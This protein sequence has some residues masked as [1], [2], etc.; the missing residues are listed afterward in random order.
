MQIWFDKEI[1]AACFLACLA[2]SLLP[3]VELGF[4]AQ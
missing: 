2:S 4:A 1:P 3:E